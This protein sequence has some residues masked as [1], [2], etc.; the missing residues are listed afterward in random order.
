MTL[1]PALPVWLLI[2]AAAVVLAAAVLGRRGPHRI[3]IVVAVLLLGA[4]LRPVIGDSEQAITRVAGERDPTV[5]LVVDR[6]PEMSGPAMAQA[7]SDMAALI[8][9]YPDARFAVI[10]FAARPAL[11]WP[12]SAD[13]F[14]LRPVVSTITVDESVPADTANAGAAAN[15]LRYQLIGA[16]QQFPRAR[17][18]VFYL[19]SGT[20]G[21][22][23][24][25]REFDLPEAAVDG[26][27]VLGYRDAGTAALRGV[28]EQ[29][30]VPFVPREPDRPLDD[31]LGADDMTDG[32]SEAGT[33]APAGFELYWALSGVAAVLLLGVLYQALRELRRTRLDRVAVGR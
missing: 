10:G 11:D 31:L 5:F 21:S 3:L 18:L 7:R 17:N 26:G 30:G 20:P 13:R 33:Q 19:G 28:A 25:P 4:L 27:A 12:L 24:P 9:R 22:P 1:Q 14:S 8:D 29:I 6:S 32:G 15:V 2:A 16:T 23:L